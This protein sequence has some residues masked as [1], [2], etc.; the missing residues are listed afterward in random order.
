MQGGDR[1]G[2]IEW[3]EKSKDELIDEIFRLQD[4]VKELQEK[5]THQQVPAK[6]IKDSPRKKRKRWKALGRAVGHPGSTRAK[7]SL[8]HEVVEQ[9]LEVCP[10]CGSQSLSELASEIKEHIQEDIVPA[11]V[12]A[13]K[14]IRY[15]YWCSRC[16]AKKRAPYAGEEVPYGYLGPN[17]LIHTLILKYH[18]GLSYSKMRLLFEELCSLKVTESALAQALQRMSRWL[19]VEEK[20]IVEAIRASPY[21]HIDETGWKIAGENHWLWDFVNERLALYRIRK[22]RGRKVLEE[23]ISD[24]YRGI[25]ISD[26]LSAYNQ[27]G[28]LR[29]RCLVHLV[30]ELHE[31]R[32]KDSSQ[33]Y[34][35]MEKNLRRILNDAK[36]LDAH[37]ERLVPW[38]F[39]SRLRR[40]K[41]RLFDLVYQAY[42]NKNC[43]RLSKRLWLRWPELLT[44]LDVAGLPNNNNH[45]E[46]MIRPN[47]IFR[48]IS[49][50][51]MSQKGS[52]AHEV[53]MSILQTLRLQNKP[54]IAFF[55]TAYLKHRQG[56]PTPIFSL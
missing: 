26:F 38:R 3:F 13:T 10:D 55:K 21:I 40:I 28:R 2:R 31:C 18:H 56:N 29:Q 45:A 8:I 4:T 27:S 7:P 24:Q 12:E 48:K 32:Q 49:F 22:S 51:N 37:R 52:H 50:Q 19:E 1:Q 23:V 25:T 15:G 30:R 44:F 5:L 35:A 36:R 11:R 41:Q 9:R 43:K 34:L 54:A 39:A 46:R 16:K 33:E 42:Q 17:V 6:L 20:E 14:F 47:V 53:L